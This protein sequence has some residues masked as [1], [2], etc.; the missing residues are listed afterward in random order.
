MLTPRLPA[1]ARPPAP[2]CRGPGFVGRVACQRPRWAMLASADPVPGDT[3][4]GSARE[5]VRLRGAGYRV[6]RGRRR[7]M[8]TSAQRA[9]GRRWCLLLP[10]ARR[11]TADGGACARAGGLET[12]RTSQGLG[13]SRCAAA[14]W[15]RGNRQGSLPRQGTAPGRRHFSFPS[16][17]A[18]RTATAWEY[19][20]YPS[21][22]VPTGPRRWAVRRRPS[23][24][25]RGQHARSPRAAPGGGGGQQRASSCGQ[26]CGSR[27]PPQPR[28]ERAASMAVPMMWPGGGT[29]GPRSPTASHAARA[30]S[31]TLPAWHGGRQSRPAENRS[32]GARAGSA[33]DEIELTRGSTTDCMRQSRR[34]PPPPSK[35]HRLVGSARE[36]GSA[37]CARAPRGCRSCCAGARCADSTPP[38]SPAGAMGPSAPRASACATHS[39]PAGRLASRCLARIC[40]MPSSSARKAACGTRP[41]ASDDV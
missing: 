18:H 27:Q 3:A 13:N 5:P 26:V 29:W 16:S 9:Q 32:A 39:Y 4:L 34:P 12:L 36:V 31:S 1:V 37:A 23:G 10:C 24:R 40:P 11:L 25:A 6:P 20:L 22:G 41:C 30:G 33:W 17:C 35:H 19:G 14:G 8:G 15:R 28:S 21:P 2:P 7:S 38:E